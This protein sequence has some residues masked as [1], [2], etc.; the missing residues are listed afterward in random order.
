MKTYTIVAGVDGVG[1]TSLLGVL[2]FMNS[3]LGEIIGV[4]AAPEQSILE[5]AK[6]CISQGDCFTHETTLSFEHTESIFQLA[7]KA[8]YY[9]KMFYIGLDSVE[10][11]L[12]R[13]NLRISRGGHAVSEEVVRWHYEHRFDSICDILPF[14]DE[15]K[16]YDNWNG[17][18]LVAE[19]KG[20]Q[21]NLIED[22]VPQWISELDTKLK[23]H[24]QILDKIFI[25]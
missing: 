15:G 17:F 14:C 23:T 22:D 6:D 8:G 20:N 19:Y 7:K 2:K 5:R 16:F 1:K 24:R 11:S 3:D 4:N 25:K 12:F 18:K 21:I 10:E 13:V 9:I